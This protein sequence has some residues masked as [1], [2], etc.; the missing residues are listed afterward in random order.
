M[1]T[2]FEMD[3]SR[4]RQIFEQTAAKMNLAAVSVEKDFWVCWTLDQ[5]FKLTCGSHLTFKGGTSLSK[6]WNLIERFS[7][8]VDITIHRDLL[9]FGGD[10]APHAAP[11]KNQLKKRLDALKAE[12]EQYIAGP[13]L[14]ELETKIESQLPER[15]SWSLR[16]DNQDS[17]TLLFEY[18]SVFPTQSEYLRRWVQIEMGGRA[19]VVPSHLVTIRPYIA[20]VF[21]GVFPD[22]KVN[23]RAILPIRTFWEK[24]M[25]L[26][27]EGFRPA[28][29]PRKNSLARHYYDIYRMI[30]AGIGNEAL[31]DLTLFFDIA[32]QRE[33]YFRYTWVD[34]ST[35]EPG[36]LRILP[37]DEDLP[38]W[39]ADYNSMQREMFFGDVPEF[40]EV[41][42]KAK[43]FQNKF[44]G[45]VE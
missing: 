22:A 31:A 15:S 13:L 4:R 39:Q 25:L 20:E 30:K 3:H 7:E 43:E 32:A 28:N 9:G 26:H 38:R 10:N 45:V 2:L 44:N 21:P 33:Q 14:S 42:E 5:L 35:Y 8:D 19:D 6:A 16:P 24:A 34:Y 12:C 29:K 40:R 27:E 36:Q 18:P 1:N 11:S 23:V 37:N 41:L 17:Q